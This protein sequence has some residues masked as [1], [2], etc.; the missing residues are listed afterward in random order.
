M[1]LC[2]KTTTTTHLYFNLLLNRS[3]VVFNYQPTQ[4]EKAERDLGNIPS[5]VQVCSLFF[6]I[7]KFQLDFEKTKMNAKMGLVP[8]RFLLRGLHIF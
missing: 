4:C 1:L 6:S 8:G 5:F 3:I 7:G 2:L